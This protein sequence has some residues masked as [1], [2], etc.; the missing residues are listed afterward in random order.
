MA[1]ENI[2]HARVGIHLSQTLIVVDQ[3]H[4][5]QIRLH[6]EVRNHSVVLQADDRVSPLFRGFGLFHDPGFQ[7]RA[8]ISAG[9]MLIC[10]GL[11]VVPAV[12][13]RVN[14]NNGKSVLG[15]GR[16][17]KAASLISFR[18]LKSGDYRIILI[19]Q[20]SVNFFIIL[21]G[22]AS[23]RHRLAVF[24]IK[25]HG[26]GIIQ[27][28]VARGYVYFRSGFHLK[29]LQ[30]FRQFLMALFF[31]VLSQI[32][33]NQQHIRIILL[34]SIQQRRQERVTLREHFPIAVQVLGKIRRIPNQVRGQIVGVR[35]NRDF[36]ALFLYRV[37]SLRCH[38]RHSLG[39]Q[40]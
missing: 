39:Y 26:V 13:G 27:I 15:A 25:I 35:Q 5:Q 19:N 17:G 31:S 9:L 3:I 7:I 22:G 33:G 1:G 37:R 24:R 36:Q 6:A 10:A 32:A 20:I 34:Y 11:C 23:R 29:L 18:G 2:G 8:Y 40:H 16:V 21:L 12:A 28:M 30:L 38:G 14:G 4:G